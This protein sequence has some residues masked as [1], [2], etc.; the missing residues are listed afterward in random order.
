MAGVK[1]RTRISVEVIRRGPLFNG[2]AQV[3]V[4][5]FL[6]TAVRDVTNMTEVELHLA[7]GRRFKHPTGKFESALHQTMTTPYLRT[8][9]DPIVYGPWLEGT[10]KRNQSTRFKGY[11]LFRRTTAKM[12][13]LA[14]PLVQGKLDAL[15]AR[16]NA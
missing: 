1:G 9:L 14:G 4:A 13:K 11:H 6:A 5:D 2:H 10:S 8:V 7:M 15:V 16:L 12:R 3:A